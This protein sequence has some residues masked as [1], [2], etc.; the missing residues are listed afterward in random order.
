MSEKRE[1][2]LDKMV[3]LFGMESSFVIA[4]ATLLKDE[5]ISDEHLQNILDF[6]INTGYP[7]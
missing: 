6:Y 2:M 7:M 3:S 5:N 1:E 4:F